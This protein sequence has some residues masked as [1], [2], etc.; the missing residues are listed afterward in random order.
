MQGRACIA[1]RKRGIGVGREGR[2]RGEER[3]KILTSKI[4]GVERRYGKVKIF[5]GKMT[6]KIIGAWKRH[7]KAGKNFFEETKKG[8]YNIVTREGGGGG[9]CGGFR[10]LTNTKSVIKWR[11]MRVRARKMGRNAKKFAASRAAQSCLI[12]QGAFFAAKKARARPLV[13]PAKNIVCRMSGGSNAGPFL[14][15]AQ[16]RAVNCRAV[17][18]TIRRPRCASFQTTGVCC[19]PTKGKEK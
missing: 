16:P 14:S 17:S 3:Q 8:D 10:V 6:G 15:A 5:T 2:E 19:R 1:G 11:K 7:L 18:T 9:S 13:A 12:F 4:T